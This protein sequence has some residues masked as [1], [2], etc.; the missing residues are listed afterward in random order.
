M[1]LTISNQENCTS[2]YS[3]KFQIDIGDNQF[4][5]QGQERKDTCEGDSGGPLI[6]FELQANKDVPRYFLIGIVSF[7]PRNCGTPNL[8]AVFTRVS[9]H[10]DW[11]LYHIDDDYAVIN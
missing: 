9:S 1:T 4:C 6:R 8:P 10:I 2:I 11:I 5:T 7:G 3:S